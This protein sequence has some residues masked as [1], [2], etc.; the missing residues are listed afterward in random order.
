[1]TAAELRAEF[2]ES[3]TR[4]HASAFQDRAFIP[5]E[6]PVACAGRVFDADEMVHLVD[7]AL[8]FWLTTGR[9]AARFEHEFARL[10]GVRHA[11]L[12]NS[13]SSANLLA[14]AALTSP[15]LAER[16]L[17]KGDEVITIAAVF[18]L[19]QHGLLPVMEW[20][21]ESFHQFAGRSRRPS[22]AAVL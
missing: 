22:T 8:D 13:G 15:K 4:F 21:A 5:G 12:C 14:L 17:R 11:M 6:T 19:V 9:Y 3:A 20:T 10:A 16:R 2:V 1:M 7:S 18:P